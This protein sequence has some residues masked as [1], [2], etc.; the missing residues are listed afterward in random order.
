MVSGPRRRFLSFRQE[1]FQ[2]L[3]T[4]SISPHRR[5]YTPGLG[6]RDRSDGHAWIRFMT[7]SPLS[8]G[9]QT[10]A[11]VHGCA[12]AHAN[13]HERRLCACFVHSLT[14]FLSVCTTRSELQHPHS[15]NHYSCPAAVLSTLAGKNSDVLSGTFAVAHVDSRCLTRV[16]RSEY[17]PAMRG[18]ARSGRGSFTLYAPIP[19][20][21]TMKERREE[22]TAWSSEKEGD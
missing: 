5:L 20:C 12:D 10:P 21:D 16:G 14:R 15:N 19:H 6:C 22:S 9:S 4:Q 1:S 11:R 2:Y 3:Y 8:A 18:V 13:L 7:R 17:I